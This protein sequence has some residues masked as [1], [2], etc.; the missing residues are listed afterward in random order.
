[1]PH[2]PEAG[3]RTRRRARQRAPAAGLDLSGLDARLS[4]VEIVVATDVDNPLLGTRGATA[5]FAPQKR[6]DAVQVDALEAALDL[7]AGLV[8]RSVAG[9]PGAGAA[10]GVGFAA[11]A[12]LG[13]RVRPGVEVVLELVGCA[14]HLRDAALI[15][16]REGPWRTPPA[17]A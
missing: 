11:L 8:D 15:V 9:R 13:A 7:W 5:V 3:N 12:T 1:V 6:A 4:G 16:T 14:D 10:G 2:E 17:P